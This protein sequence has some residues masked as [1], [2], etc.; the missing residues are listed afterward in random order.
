LKRTYLPPQTNTAA[1]VLPFTQPSLEVEALLAIY[2][3]QSTKEQV[4]RN[5]EAYDQQTIGLVRQAIE[6][7]WSREHIV[8]YI[9]NKRKD[10]QW[11]NASGRL[12]IDQ[13]EGLQA[14][15]ER[16]ER[17]EVKTVMVWAV[18]RLFRDEDMIQPAV[19]V[20]L[21]KDHHCIILT[22]D[23]LF[24]FNI[25]K[26]D[27][28][29]RFLELA[30]AAADYVTHHVRGRML[31]A[32]AQIS[33]RGLA[34]GRRI[35]VGYIVVD[36]ERYLADGSDNP[37]WRRFVIYE[38]HAKVIRWLFRRLRQLSG[39]LRV[40]HREI[41]AWPFVFPYFEDPE[42]S[43]NINLT[44]NGKGYTL[45]R[46]GLASILTNVVYIGR[47]YYKGVVT[48]NNH[49]PIVSD[50]DFWYAF[51]RLSSVTIEGE[52]RPRVATPPARYTHDGAPPLEALLDGIV[53][54]AVEGMAVYA[55]RG[56]TPPNYSIFDEG[57]KHGEHYKQ[58]IA[59]D[60][61]DAIFTQRLLH[62][63]DNTE[64]GAALREHLSDLHKD[65]D[66][67][68]VSVDSQIAEAKQQIARWER[69]KR[70]AREE[71]DEAGEREAVRALKGKNAALRE[72]EMKKE[73]ANVDDAEVVELMELLFGTSVTWA[74]L[75]YSNRQ[76]FIR[77]ATE[78]VTLREASTQ[79]LELQIVW[80]GPYARTDTAYIWRNYANGGRYTEEDKA[81]LRELYPTAD[82]AEILDRLP[83]R[84]WKGIIIQAC[85]MG[86]SRPQYSC[87][88]SSG[89]HRDLSRSDADIVAMLG[90]EYEPDWPDKL[91]W[92]VGPPDTD[93]SQDG[94][95][96]KDV[97]PSTLVRRLLYRRRKSPDEV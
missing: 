68:L 61:L 43:R 18:D 12:R 82:R 47:W 67:Q 88:N 20:K 91:T 13:R 10:G 15:C 36:R 65:R 83:R 71:D 76:R 39:N 50:D 27:D 53:T 38:P 46:Q 9:E 66:Q 37:D 70:I 25:A 42:Y 78:S 75:I 57:R 90:V 64:H 49:D 24:D 1:V 62:V 29:K 17:D 3:R 33:K 8:I 73:Q 74:D 54:G 14:L 2:A 44:D 32:R 79:F 89:I 30:Q 77:A 55:L 63:L 22:T 19:F 87:P 4:I 28:R 86:L 21:C 59:I 51:N 40:L 94:N 92:W 34:D 16:I 81:V 97:L 48:E 69:S 72:L 5:R 96:I 85:R 80:K 26:R 93:S 11:V 84:S 45:T 52:P 23:D 35:N 95:T 60:E 56:E 58:S 6:Y 7:G 41:E 31:P